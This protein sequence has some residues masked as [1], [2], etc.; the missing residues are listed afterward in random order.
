MLGSGALLA[1]LLV[2]RTPF[3]AAQAAA[4][5]RAWNAAAYWA[6]ADRLQDHLDAHWGGDAYNPG[7]SM[8]NANMLL[9]HAAAALAGHTGPARQDERA[10]KIITALCEGK[11]WRTRARRRPAGPRPGLDGLARRAPDAAPGGRHRDRVGA[12]DRLARARGARA[13][14]GAPPT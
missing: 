9:T 14:P 7:R 4:D 3:A 1:S 13:R 5:P 11:A 6:F 12:G 2:P 10:R 8:Y